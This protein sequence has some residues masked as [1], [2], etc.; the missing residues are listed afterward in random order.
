ML[1]VFQEFLSELLEAQKKAQ[2]NRNCREVRDV[3]LMY[4][5]YDTEKTRSK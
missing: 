4:H 1:P 2:E 5:A 3:L